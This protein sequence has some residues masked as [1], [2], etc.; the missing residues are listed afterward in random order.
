MRQ[1]DQAKTFILYGMK[2]EKTMEKENKFETMEIG[3]CP[4]CGSENISYGDFE[5]DDDCCWYESTCDDCDFSF[6]EHY[7]MVF[8]ISCGVE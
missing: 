1:E 5:S 3:K 7:R 2:K 8:E 6:N 4:K